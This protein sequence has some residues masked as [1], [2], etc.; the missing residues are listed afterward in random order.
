MGL[1][2]TR[3]LSD[4]LGIVTDRYIYDAFGRT[5]GQVGSTGNV[6]L[7][8]GEQRDAATGLDY[9][10]AR[11]LD[12]GTGRFFGQD[13]FAGFKIQPISLHDY[14]YGNANPV[15]YVDP[16]GQVSLSSLAVGLAIRGI[17]VAARVSKITTGMTSLDAAYFVGALVS[18]AFYWQYY[19]NEIV[20]KPLGGELLDRAARAKAGLLVPIPVGKQI[21]D[22]YKPQLRVFANDTAA[23]SLEISFDI[24]GGYKFRGSYNFGTQKWTVKGGLNHRIWPQGDLLSSLA[25]VEAGVRIGIG[26]GPEGISVP[27]QLILEFTAASRMRLAFTIETDLTKP[28]F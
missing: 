18:S 21:Y 19:Y 23:P 7:F 22:R 10:R 6:Y 5:I 17:K 9:L 13:P 25:K 26:Y 12:V 4:A 14:V 11:Y 8:A 3:A 2:S 1:G 27:G 20:L 28:L 15:T 24:K 16:S